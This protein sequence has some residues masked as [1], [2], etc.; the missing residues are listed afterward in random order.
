MHLNLLITA[1]YFIGLKMELNTCKPIKL[2]S[3]RDPAAS[4]TNCDWGWLICYEILKVSSGNIGIHEL[5]KTIS[6]GFLGK[7]DGDW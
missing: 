5:E 6:I 4:K 1:D 3:L 7:S 2:L